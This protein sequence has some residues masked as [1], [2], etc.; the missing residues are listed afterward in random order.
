MTRERVH[1]PNR[2]AVECLSPPEAADL[3]RAMKSMLAGKWHPLAQ[4]TLEQISEYSWSR[5]G[6]FSMR[7]LAAEIW[8]LRKVVT[9]LEDEL[10]NATRIASGLS[11]TIDELHVEL[12]AA[13]A[14]TP[15][16]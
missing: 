14:S 16:K 8:R 9:T 1:Q 12:T 13:R 10:V 5:Q 3:E 6:S 15:S 2:D 7:L 4:V 11:R